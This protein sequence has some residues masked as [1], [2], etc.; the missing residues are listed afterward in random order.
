M[1]RG[2]SWF[3]PAPV[4]GYGGPRSFALP[5]FDPFW[6]RCVEHDVLVA[7][8]SSDS[9]Y[10]RYTAEWDGSG[11]EMLPFQT[12]TLRMVNAWRPVEDAVASWVC[13]GGLFRNPQ[14]KLAVIENGSIWLAPLLDAPG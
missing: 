7:M 5:E 10:A 11:G 4:P 13:H 1:A 8:H 6:R 3:G 9:G 14:L 2:R 12:N